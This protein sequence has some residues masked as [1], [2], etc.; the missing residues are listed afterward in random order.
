[1][2]SNGGFTLVMFVLQDG[3]HPG[4]RYIGL[5]PTHGCLSFDGQPNMGFMN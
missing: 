4:S 3:K 2:D 1:M 5:S